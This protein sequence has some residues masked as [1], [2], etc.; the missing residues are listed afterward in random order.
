VS[1]RSFSSHTVGW[2]A[3]ATGALS[4]A[5]LVFIILFYTVGQPFATLNDLCIGLAAISSAVLAWLMYPGH[6]TLSPH[7][8]PLALVAALVGALVVAVG[9]VLVIPGVTGWYLAGLYMTA[10]NALIGLWL[11]GLSYSARQSGPWPQVLA[12]FGLV[13]GVI[14]AVG[15]VAVPGILR[16]VEAQAAAPWY[17]NAEYA[18]GLGSM[19][20]YPIWCI[21]LGRILLLK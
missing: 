14:M 16:G 1:A 19:I 17:V 20:L 13:A 4:L 12:V 7:L 15:L 6:H 18:G 5:G 2:M 10:G 9:P 8:S 21:W 11:I 3:I